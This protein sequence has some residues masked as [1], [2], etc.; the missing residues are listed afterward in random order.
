[1]CID[2]SPTTLCLLIHDRLIRKYFM[3]LANYRT[4]QLTS[5]V[6]YEMCFN[7]QNWYHN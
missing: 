7:Q 1:M 5:S 3:M 4:Y 2:S 6:H